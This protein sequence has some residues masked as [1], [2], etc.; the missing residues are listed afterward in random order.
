VS[1]L[2]LASIIALLALAVTFRLLTRT[3]GWGPGD[4]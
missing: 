1:V 3:F 4:T 2:I